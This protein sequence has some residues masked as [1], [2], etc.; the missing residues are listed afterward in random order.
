MITTLHSTMMFDLQ[1]LSANYQLVLGLDEDYSSNVITA[2][3][4]KHM[5]SLQGDF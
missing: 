3:T 1:N 5:L 2:S 4:F